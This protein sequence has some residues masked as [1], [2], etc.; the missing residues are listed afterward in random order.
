MTDKMTSL[1]QQIK[2]NAATFHGETVDPTYIN[3]FFGK[4]GAG[5]STLADAF[6]HPECLEWQTGVNA[7]DYTILVYDQDFINRNL[8]DYGDLKGVF[9][10]SEENAETRRQIDEKTEE[11]K[12]VITDGKQAAEDRDK[13][14][15]E[16]K[17]LRDAFETT[18]WNTTE[19]IRRSFDQTQNGK[20]KKLQFADEVLS[21]KHAV[22][23]HKKED[24]QKLYDIA[25]DPKAR[26]YPLFK[27]STDLE[28]EYDL[29]GASYLGEEVTSRS[30]TQFAK[31]MKALNATEWVKKGHAEYVDHS[32]GRCPFCQGKLPESFE[33]DIALAF[34]ENYQ[35]AL[36]ALETFET[37]Y[38][39]KMAEL[40][41]LFKDNLSD[42]FPKAKTDVYEKL[43]A[44]LEALVAENEQLIA[45]KRTAPG[46]PVALK[47]TDTVI[48]AI[49]AEITAINKL[50]QENNDII[51]TK[52]DKQ[53]ECFNMVWEEIAFL[54]KSDVAAYTK[55]KAD[56]EAETKKLNDKV[57]ELQGKY[58][59]L[60][61]EITA[62][63]ASVI[64]TTATVDSINAHLKDSGF[65]G[66]TLHEKE[67]VKG[68]Y[69][70]IRE[71]GNIADR[72]SE[73]ERNFIAFLYFYHVVRGSQ[74][75]TDSGKDKI[76]IIDDPVSSM[77]SSALFIVSALVREM[78]GVCSNNVSGA[79]VR[80]NGTEYEGKYIQQL[81]ILTHNAFFHREITYN[82]V[83]H[84]RYV[85]FFK[86][87]KKNNVS[88]VE[89]CVIEATKVSEKDR[90]YNPV[91]NSYNALW[92]EYETLDSPIPLMNVI[93]R[94]LEYYFIQLC[95]VDN[96]VLSTTV[97]EAVKKKINEEAGGGVPDY[98]KY[99]LAQAMLSYIDRSD[100]FNDGM[101]F[102][103]E[104]IDCDQYRDVFR[105]IFDVMGHGQHF[106]RMMA[107]AD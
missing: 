64:N 98:T 79:A 16:L 77:D 94:I 9:T 81:F 29:S 72:L 88:S 58:R 66:F 28:G 91:Q 75:E 89:K 38:V 19:E 20:K 48:A 76:V 83:S 49:D 106:K 54:L 27:S 7:S 69:E 73:G 102:V 42:V 33:T 21:G 4:N 22:V 101:H 23:E 63:N 5:K 84:Y 14:K 78:I 53:L 8:A 100:A 92:R 51:A 96:N 87:N 105:T 62:L 37:D 74:S 44:Q 45:K 10:L 46:E 15:G 31:F 1:V 99:H 25:Y 40:I 85:S 39:A 71:D 12:T 93:R 11:R 17:P 68:T 50:V 2:L 86:V 35:K 36:D 90:N 57:I 80:G 47:D 3:F 41:Q 34:D 59:K 61:G 24:I 55:S 103:D 104:S 95:A 32:E 70:V 13:K 67:G 82:Q 43:V 97:L 52:P 107:E 26:K 18:C 6:R 56:I 65:E 30:E 60:S